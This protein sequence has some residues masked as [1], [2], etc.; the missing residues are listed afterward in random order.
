MQK[1]TIFANVR[2]MFQAVRGDLVREWSRFAEDHG[3]K[4]Q[5]EGASMVLKA[6]L[7]AEQNLVPVLCELWPDVPFLCEE[8]ENSGLAGLVPGIQLLPYGDDVVDLP[9]NFVSVDGVD[10]SAL[11]DNQV[12]ELVAMMAGLLKDGKPSAGIVQML[13]EVEMYHCGISSREVYKGSKHISEWQVPKRPLKKS[14]I[15]TDDNKAVDADFRNLVINKLTGSGGTRYPMNTPSGAGP[16]NVLRGRA[17]AFVS[18]NARNW[19]QVA[20]AALIEAS[21]G[22]VR[23]LDG[24][25]VPWNQVRMPAVVFARDEETFDYVQKLSQGWLDLQ[26]SNGIIVCRDSA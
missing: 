23:C 24:S 4:Q 22:V 1:N 14:L 6:D 7:Y 2:V 17:A 15:C 16:I 20:T 3:E 11:Y 13:D 12:F 21:D 19:D 5:R 25:E 26:N 10:G 9:E 18:S 8:A